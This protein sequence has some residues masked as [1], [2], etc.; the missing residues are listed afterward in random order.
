MKPGFALTFTFWT[1]RGWD[2]DLG[3]TTD[4]WKLLWSR[5]HT[6]LMVQFGPFWLCTFDDNKT[7]WKHSTNK[8]WVEGEKETSGDYL[9]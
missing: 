3:I 5:C 6:G 8:N 9:H 7:E 2:I 4:K 1:G